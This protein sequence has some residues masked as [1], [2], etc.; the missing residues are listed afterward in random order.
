M[1]KDVSCHTTR[2]II[3]YVRRQ[4]GG[5]VAGLLKDISPELSHLPHPESYLTDLNNWVS[6]T[7]AKDMFARARLILGDEEAA[8]KIG[9]DA[10]QG[11][12]FGYVQKIYLMTLP[13]PR[14]ALR[15]AQSINDKFNR[16][17]RVELVKLGKTEAVVRLH[18]NRSLDLSRDFCLFN[19]GIYTAIPT[20][21]DMPPASLR[22]ERC[23]FR[24]DPYCEYQGGWKEKPL[25]KRIWSRLTLP[26]R[27]FRKA[28][29]Q[30]ERDQAL[31]RSKFDET[32]RL[33]LS[34]QRKIEQLSS[35][36]ETSKGIVSILDLPLLLERIL[37]LMAPVMR[38]DRAL[39]FLV[40]DERIS[41]KVAHGWQGTRNAHPL[42]KPASGAWEDLS[43][44]LLAR[45]VRNGTP[46]WAGETGLPSSALPGSVLS[47]FGSWPLVTIPLMSRGKTIGVLAADRGMGAPPLTSED[48]DILM[49]FSNHIAIAIENARLYQDLKSNY[50]STVQS[51]ALA[52]EA[53]DPYTRGHSERV[54]LYALQIAEEMGLDLQ[55]RE[56]LQCAGLLHDIG[57]IGVEEKILRKKGPLEEEEYDAV[58]LHPLIGARILRPIPLLGPGL[59]LI[60]RHHESFDGRGYPDGLRAE[61]IPLAARILKVADSYDAMTSDRPYR[62]RLSGEEARGELLS[63]SGSQFDPSV[64]EAFLRVL[65][66]DR[67]DVPER[68]Q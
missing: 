40:E 13:H 42:P 53:K 24:G 61:D 22:E 23:F 39:L 47:A 17:I 25:I 36:C 59:D 51:L 10:V 32:H 66:R 38:F 60:I 65:E 28:L 45:V 52:L 35:I 41:L 68:R 26:R 43:D 30:M 1:Q 19:Q 16:T 31:L 7:L 20:I 58:K 64:V 27:V 34:L 18:W 9:Y 15:K 56:A 5:D 3:E 37:E 14:H 44:P 6:S 50:L 48:R 62:S 55:T 4:T 46:I 12:Q 8:Y 11:G 63:K 49:A 54:T 29:F 33:N 67:R 57:K 2:A 21:W